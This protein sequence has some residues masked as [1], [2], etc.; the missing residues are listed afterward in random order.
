ME[1]SAYQR[2]ARETSQ[3]RLG[4]PQGAIA[5]MLGLASETGSIL[6]IYKKY[7]RDGID[8]AANREFLRE[9]L[10]DLL[11][12]AAAV[13]TACG[14]DLEDI[15]EANLRRTRDRYPRQRT[16]AECGDL[17]VF[18]AGYPARE[19]FPR[20]LVV[21]VAERVLPSGR[22][23]AVLTLV[24][25]EPDAFPDGPV[26]IGGKLA[27]YRVGAELG[28]PLTD[29]ARRVDA[30]RFHDAIHLGLMAVLGWS[31]VMRALLRLKRKSSPDA[32][33]CEDGARAIFAEEGLAA[34]LSRLAH[35]RTGFLSQTSIDGVVIEVAK[36][37]A[38]GL[39][40]EVVPGW[41]WQAAIHQGFCAMHLLDQ[42]GGGYLVANLGDHTP[43][44][45]VLW[46]TERQDDEFARLG[47]PFTGLWGRPLHA[48]DCQG[49]F[50]ETDKYCREAA[51]ELASARKRIKARFTPAPEPIRLFFPPKWGINNELPIQPVLSDAKPAQHEQA[52]LF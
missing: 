37:A 3:L 46:M 50:C 48:I 42:N 19:R 47:L 24:S 34:M 14:L 32:D 27:G 43:A 39:E 41:L 38:T 36:A 28:D 35:G 2:A 44:E 23:A 26:A 18:D 13:A 16:E 30:Y 6:N 8:L 17:P 11:W 5:P 4:G 21:A 29:N 40:A 25:A 7:L 22:P 52:A 12:Y 1:F 15:A 31:P 10:G 49:L 51:P 20:R 33:E 9:E 45:I